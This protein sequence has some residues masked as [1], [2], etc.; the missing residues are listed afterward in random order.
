LYWKYVLLAYKQLV[1]DMED[2]FKYTAS[3]EPLLSQPGD[4]FMGTL[5]KQ[6]AA[7]PTATG[8]GRR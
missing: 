5:L 4:S 6:L 3:A 2:Y 7:I 1:P 8:S